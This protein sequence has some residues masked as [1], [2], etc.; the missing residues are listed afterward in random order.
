MIIKY[1]WTRRV[2]TLYGRRAKV[3]GWFL[4]GIIPLYIC[5]HPVEV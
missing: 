4:L 1:V 3:E 5:L 2:D